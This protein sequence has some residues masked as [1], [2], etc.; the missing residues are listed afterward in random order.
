MI[1]ETAEAL[2][3]HIEDGR[4]QV[5]PISEVAARLTELTS[6]P[7]VSA[8]AIVELVHHDPGLASALLRYANSAALGARV[9]IVSVHQAVVHL[10]IECVTQVALA[11]SLRSGVFDAPAYAVLTKAHWVR[12]ISTALVAKRIARLLAQNVEVAFLCGL[13]WPI[14]AMLVLRALGEMPTRSGLPA[15]DEADVL[16][17]EMNERF[18][19]A[20]IE[21]WSLP[22]VVSE[23]LGTSAS[24]T[25]KPVE[26]QI[27]SL[28]Y[29]IAPQLLVEGPHDVTAL[30]ALPA[31]ESL[32]LYPEHFEELFSQG[33]MLGI[34]IE[35]MR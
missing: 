2:H 10:G 30:T 12:S 3:R 35:A 23:A 26:A 27:A 9:E 11:A 31:A 5:P 34:E 6:N 33:E 18:R 13:L 21:A 22:K 24:A 32:N 1:E 15:E 20:A 29:E 7:D 16:A 25:A 28:A 4:F 19:E 8:A 17:T 14:G